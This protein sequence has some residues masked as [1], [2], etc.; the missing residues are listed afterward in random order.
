[1]I[2]EKRAYSEK[3]RSAMILLVRGLIKLGESGPFLGEEIEKLS[4]QNVVLDLS[5]ID[6]IDSTGIG[7]MV[8]ICGELAKKGRKLALLNAPKRITDLLRVAHLD[9]I[10]NVFKSA[11][12]AVASFDPDAAA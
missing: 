5:M 11:K 4:G 12:E 2:I 10:F 3:G 1:M 7:E 6:Y 9:E 8:F